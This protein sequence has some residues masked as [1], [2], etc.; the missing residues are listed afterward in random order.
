MSLIEAVV[1]VVV[2]GVTEFLPISSSGHTILASWLLGWDVP[3]LAFDVA[4]HVG[5]LVAVLL[6]FGRDWARLLR[7]AVAG[8][9]VVLGDGVGARPAN[10]RRVL[11][12][13]VLA[14]VPIGLVGLFFR[15]VLEDSV[16]QPV[17]VGAFLLGTGVFIALGERFGRR[18]RDV[19]DLTAASAGGIGLAQAVAVLPGI[20]RSGM[21][22][23]AGLLGGMTRE[24]A[25]RFAFYLA[26][27][28]ILGPGIVLAVDLVREG[29]SAGSGVGVLAAGA[30]VSFATALLAIRGL[31]ALLRRGSLWPF[32][33]YCLA[34]GA[35]VL[36]ARA[37]GA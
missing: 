30:A 1:L 27:P 13:V 35:A 25:A 9:A 5:T 29:A 18:T 11:A 4:V 28:A 2:Q 12:L 15:G 22:I 6:Y 8:E 7:G 3:G 23:V 33:W 36:I 32:V 20:S 14:T 17:T 21:S 19:A 26:V 31:M 10:A 16:R 37:A 34:A 24:A